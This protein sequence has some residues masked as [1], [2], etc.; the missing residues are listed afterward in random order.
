MSKSVGDAPKVYSDAM[1][2]DVFEARK[3]LDEALEALD[4]RIVIVMDDIDRLAADEIAELFLILKAVADFP[5][6]VYLLAFDHRV[7][8]RAI[9]QKLGVNGKTYLEKIVQL[10]IELPS[11]GYSAIQQ[12]F[13]EQ[14]GELLDA[15]DVSE[16]LKQ[17]FGNLFHDGVKHFL[18][19]PRASKKLLNTLRFIYPPLKGEVYFPDLVGVA[20]LFTCVPSAVRVIANHSEAFTGA[21]RYG[22]DRKELR[23][24]HDKWLEKVEPKC[25]SHVEGIV[26][27]LFPKFGWALDGPSYATEFEATWRRQ[28]RVCSSAHF[29]K[30]FLFGLPGGVISEAE[31]A[32]IAELVCFAPAGL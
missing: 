19:T 3:Q 22:E 7:V 2:T 11:V 27:R 6:T 9:R 32:E 1:R 29:D 31:W 15:M 18:T 4:R 16:Q 30:Y 12:M 10:Q 25:R 23:A 26:K 21:E 17:D 13:L 5:K 20:T 28:L 8:R 14:V 24:F